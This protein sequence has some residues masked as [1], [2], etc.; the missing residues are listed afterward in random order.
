[1]STINYKIYTHIRVSLM[2]IIL[3]STINYTIYT[4]TRVSLMD[5]ILSRIHKIIFVFL[6]I[7]SYLHN[8]YRI[9]N[10]V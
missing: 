4:H 5:I 2:D 6:T 7:F 8:K 1:M 3:M 9:Y 10:F